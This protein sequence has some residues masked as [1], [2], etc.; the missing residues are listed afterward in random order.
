MSKKVY[1]LL[2]L[3][4]VASLVLAACGSQPTEAPAEE[5]M[6][7]PMEEVD[8]LVCQVTDTG[9]IDDASFNQTAWAGVEQ[10]EAELGIQSAFLESQEQADYETNIQAFI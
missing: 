3:L 9:G 5:P 6:E 8:F 7:E 2:G 1:Y 10:A 4:L